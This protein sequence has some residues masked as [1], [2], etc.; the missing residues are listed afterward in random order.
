MKQVTSKYFRDQC[1]KHY[2]GLGTNIT[3]WKH[4]RRLLFSPAID[5]ATGNILIPHSAIAYDEGCFMSKNYSAEGF[6][7]RFIND[8]DSTYLYTEYKYAE[9]LCREAIFKPHPEVA[10]ALDAELKGEYE[11]Q[12]LVFFHSGIKANPRNLKK[13]LEEERAEAANR[14]GLLNCMQAEQIQEY[15]NALAPNQFSKILDN[16]Q[17]A[18]ELASNINNPIS[19]QIQCRV[20][21]SIKH[22]PIPVY[23]PSK[24]LNTVR[25]FST[26]AA[27][28]CLKKEVRKTLTKGWYEADL[29]NCQLA[30]V[31]MLWDISEVKEFLKRGISIW[32]V[33]V[34]DLGIEQD[35][36]EYEA[37][38]SVIKDYLYGLIFGMSLKR[39][40]ASLD[41][42]LYKQFG[43]KHG[44]KKFLDHHLIK[45]IITARSKMIAKIAGQGYGL[46]I[47][48]KKI[49]VINVS[50]G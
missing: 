24:Q 29:V 47:F 4:L 48:G 27:I 42:D 5:K 33:L 35:S 17:E 11:S 16:W 49:K 22:R 19:K 32:K 15:M 8:V 43:I 50:S 9:G 2:P 38:K 25:L 10:T 21:L 41:H 39:L 26:N 34:P 7:N 45:P 20:L 28:P 36:T 12:E 44:E 31:A 30:I 46:T 1:V 6:L 23:E 40:K 13:V 37:A 3:Y 18:Y 14:I